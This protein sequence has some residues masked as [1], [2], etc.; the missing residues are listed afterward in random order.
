MLRAKVEA[1]CKKEGITVAE[2]ERACGL[3]PAT[4]WHWNK[5]TPIVT[6]VQAVAKHFGITVEELMKDDGNE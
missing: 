6:A 4:I 2:L 5:S 1:L 3:S